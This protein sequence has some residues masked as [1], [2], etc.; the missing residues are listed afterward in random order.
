MAA[1]GCASNASAVGID[2]VA[3]VADEAFAAV[4]PITGKAVGD[5]RAKKT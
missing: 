1:P 4:A 3:D 2:V 5:I